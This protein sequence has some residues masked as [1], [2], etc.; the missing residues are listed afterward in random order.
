M[1]V[2]PRDV[3]DLAELYLQRRAQRERLRDS[4]LDRLAR[5]EA[6]RLVA[7]AWE[8][9]EELP[10]RRRRALPPPLLTIEALEMLRAAL[11]EELAALE[12]EV[13]S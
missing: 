5:V 12:A 6:A 9:N 3:A 4:L 1:P 10:P 7:E 13:G 8:A 2:D 11:V